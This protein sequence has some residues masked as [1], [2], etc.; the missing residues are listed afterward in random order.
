MEWTIILT[1][2]GTGFAIISFIYQFL[3]NF[4]SDVEKKFEI[5]DNRIFQLAMGKTLKEILKEEK[6]HKVKK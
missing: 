4:K 3:R 1:I 5:L 2:L 6:L